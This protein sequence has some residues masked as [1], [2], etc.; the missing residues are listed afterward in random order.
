MNAIRLLGCLTLAS[1][2]TFVFVMLR[3]DRRKA[4]LADL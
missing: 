4:R 3:R 2:G 1:L